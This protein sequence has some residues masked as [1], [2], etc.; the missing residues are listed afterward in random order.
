MSVTVFILM[1]IFTLFVINL[2]T[3]Y[4]LFASQVLRLLGF[5]SQK[6]VRKQSYSGVIKASCIDGR[7]LKNGVTAVPNS[8]NENKTVNFLNC[9]RRGWFEPSVEHPCRIVGRNHCGL[10][11]RL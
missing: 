2:S 10:R 11:K 3:L 9:C 5:S 7:H 8:E 4:S 6:K 1:L